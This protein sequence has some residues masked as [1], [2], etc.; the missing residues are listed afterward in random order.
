MRDKHRGG[1]AQRR[2][3]LLLELEVPAAAGCGISPT[4]GAWG[5]SSPADNEAERSGKKVRDAGGPREEEEE[6]EEDQE[7][8]ERCAR[9]PPDRRATRGEVPHC[10]GR[11]EHRCLHCDGRESAE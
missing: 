2:W 9:C 3:L 6:E 10:H 5:E 8:E 7:E 1:C 4:Q 11:R